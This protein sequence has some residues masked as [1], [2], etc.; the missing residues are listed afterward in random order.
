MRAWTCRRRQSTLGAWVGCLC[1]SWV[2]RSSSAADRTWRR[3]RVASLGPMPELPAR[4]PTTCLPRRCRT[5]TSTWPRRARSSASGR[6]EGRTSLGASS[7]GVIQAS[8]VSGW[9]GTSP[10]ASLAFHERRP[11][12][13]SSSWSGPTTSTST[14]PRA[15]SSSSAPGRTASARAVAPRARAAPTS[16]RAFRGWSA[17]RGVVGRASRVPRIHARTSRSATTGAASRPLPSADR[18]CALPA[19]SA[20][21]SVRLF[22]AVPAGFRVSPATAPATAGAGGA[23]PMAGVPECARSAARA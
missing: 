20:S 22:I 8:P 2:S 11:A 19:S 17:M 14:L 5:G 23:P 12:R 16:G 21:T 13:A 18:R 10:P 4:S 9:R 6:C 7:T 15:C 1:F 3:A